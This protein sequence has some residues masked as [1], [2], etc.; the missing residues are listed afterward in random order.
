MRQTAGIFRNAAV[1]GEARNCLY[2]RE[3]RAAQGQPFG[4]EDARIGLAQTQSRNVLQH[5]GLHKINTS[6]R[7]GEA[8]FPPPPWSP[9]RL[10]RFIRTR[11]TQTLVHRLFGRS[12]RHRAYRNERAAIAFGVKLDMAFDLGKESMIGTHADIEAGMPGGA[13]L[14]RDD[15]AG[16]HMLAT[17]GLDAKALT[18]GIAPVAR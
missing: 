9:S 17:K 13:A 1:V 11:R 5:V 15:V 14:T 18:L 12:I 10:R 16:N 3:R 6:K 2:V 8:G 4:L 7:K